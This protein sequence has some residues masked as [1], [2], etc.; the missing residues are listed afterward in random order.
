MDAIPRVAAKQLPTRNTF[1]GQPGTH[2]QA[3]SNCWRTRTRAGV[4][5]HFVLVRKG[6]S[7]AGSSGNVLRALYQQLESGAKFGLVEG[8]A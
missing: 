3:R 5:N 4:T 8:T 7:G 6:E 2:L 1:S